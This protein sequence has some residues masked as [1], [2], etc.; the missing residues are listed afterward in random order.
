MITKI[1]GSKETGLKIRRNTTRSVFNF[2]DSS[3][4]RSS[5]FYFKSNSSKTHYSLS[6]FPSSVIVSVPALQGEE[7][8]R[9]RSALKF[10]LK[11][12]E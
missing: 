7:N 1:D 5:G 8:E 9:C 12:V 10:L 6:S 4:K 2:S 3:S 11:M